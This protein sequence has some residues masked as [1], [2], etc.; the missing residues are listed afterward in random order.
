MTL[1][2][3][4][5]LVIRSSD[6]CW[7]WRVSG[8]RLKSVYE[9]GDALSYAIEFHHFTKSVM[10]SSQLW[11]R[12]NMI[13]IHWNRI[14]NMASVEKCVFWACF[15]NIH[16]WIKIV[17]CWNLTK[18][19]WTAVAIA[20]HNCVEVVHTSNTRKYKSFKPFTLAVDVNHNQFTCNAIKIHHFSEH[21][22]SSERQGERGGMR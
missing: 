4:S 10:L 20:A 6:R 5:D 18:Q 16:F 7:W 11:N 13:K 2:Q 15:S 3:L 17:K 9:C 14:R 22:M 19:T 1:Y 21:F 12:F 8:L